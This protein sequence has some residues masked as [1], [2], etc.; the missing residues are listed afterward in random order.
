MN[1]I[2]SKYFERLR[3]LAKEDGLRYFIYERH[4]SNP[5]SVHFQ[6]EDKFGVIRNSWGTGVSKDEAFGK[7][8][9]EMIERLYFSG[10]SSFEFQKC[11]GFLKRKKNILDISETFQLQMKHLHPANTNGVAIHIS[12]QK[13]TESALLELIERHTI[14][15]SLVMEIGPHSKIVKKMNLSK[16]ARYYIW[17]GPFKT[18]VVVGALV[19]SMGCFFSSGCDFELDH[20][21]KKA[22]FELNSF[23]FL[24]EKIPESYDISKDDIQSFN[25]YHRYSG[26]DSVIRFFE[27]AIFRPLP[28]LEKKFFFK[29]IIPQPKIFDGLPKLPCVRV[30]HPDVQQLNDSYT[31]QLR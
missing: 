30:I 15:Y 23:L 21:I 8:L 13:A 14:L 28:E 5:Y 10:F 27:S 3:D 11:F 22:E 17:K 24:K 20:A 31:W 4:D 25:R 9:M 18:F 1:L 2:L 26:D 7:A 19:E 6:F 12:E 16:D 29:T